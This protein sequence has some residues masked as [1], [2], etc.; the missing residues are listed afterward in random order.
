MVKLLSKTEEKSEILDNISMVLMVFLDIFFLDLGKIVQY[1]FE[2]DLMTH[3]PWQVVIK[4]MIKKYPC[5][6]FQVLFE[7]SSTTLPPV[8]LEN[9]WKRFPSTKQRGLFMLVQ[10]KTNTVLE[11]IKYTVVVVRVTYYQKQVR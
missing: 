6:Y 9:V 7:C 11:N 4:V 5:N 2:V 3:I 1:C 8:T 10:H